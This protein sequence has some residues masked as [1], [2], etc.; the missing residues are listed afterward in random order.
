MIMKLTY[1]LFAVM[2]FLMLLIN[3]AS[4]AQHNNCIYK[5]PVFSLN[6][7]TTAN[8]NDLV[9]YNLEKYN[10]TTR[11]CPADGF[12][13]FGTAIDD[14]FEGRWHHLPEDHTAGDHNGKMM[15]VNAAE[16]PGDFFV[17]TIAG[18]KPGASYRVSGWFA[19]ICK[20]AS[21]CIPTP[22]VIEISMYANKKL[23]GSFKTGE[24]KQTETPAWQNYTGEF[25]M[26]SNTDVLS[27]Q[28]KAL[29]P[30]GCGNDFA[31]DDIEIIQCSLPIPDT[32]Q[33]QITN[34]VPD[35]FTRPL[36]KAIETRANPIIKQIT[37]EEAELIIELYDNGEIDGDTVSIYHNNNLV[38]SR[39]GIS[40]RPVTLK[41]KVDKANPHHE[42]VMVAD[43]LGRI[44]PNTS[45]M[46]ITAGKK[47][48]EIFI[49]SSEQKNAKLLIDLQ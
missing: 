3:S 18:L 38:V 2:L 6:F 49:S 12:Y 19:N 28:M 47:R 4:F 34:P 46:V 35:T 29:T 8:N 37:T 33:T 16:N 32:A 45:L 23:L 48:Y 31:L 41:V 1:K 14:C 40:T 20:Y 39:A 13:S 27:L 15:I 36:P 17:M 25:K 26:A 5:D 43:N 30:G 21:G 24:I 7:G 44:P 11:L 42:L 10:K 22:P 9:M